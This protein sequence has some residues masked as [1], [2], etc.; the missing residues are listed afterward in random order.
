MAGNVNKK[1]EMSINGPQGSVKSQGAE[2]FRYY[3]AGL[4]SLLTFLVYLVSLGNEFVSWD[5]PGYVYKNNAIRSFDL[6]SSNGP[7]LNFT[8]PTGTL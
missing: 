1:G 6:P 7:F 4:V 2:R 8:K 5:D 3:V